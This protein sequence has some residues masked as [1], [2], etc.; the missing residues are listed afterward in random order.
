MKLV[1]TFKFQESQLEEIRAKGVEVKLFGSEQEFADSG[2]YADAD[3]IIANHRTLQR[4]FLEKCEKVKWVQVAHIG[5]ERLPMDYLQERG[6]VVVNARGSLGMPIAED[7]M[8]KMLMLARKS[9]AVMNKQLAHEWGGVRGFINL[10]GKTAGI[11]GTGDVGTETA[12]R[13][14]AFGMRVIGI[15][16]TG[17]QLPEYDRVYKPEQLNEVITQ[18]DF[19]VLSLP[20][21]DQSVNLLGEEQFKLMKPTAFIINISRGALIDEEVLLDYLRGHKIAGAG[22]DVFV[23]E[24]KLGKL[25]PESPF[26]ELDNIIITPHCAGGGDQFNERFT[27]GFMHNLQLFLDGKWEQML[28]VREFGKGY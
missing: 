9:A 26:W 10:N 11:I 20:L 4:D 1:S 12:I 27:G 23:E 3:I 24:F 28:N 13:A 6:V 18:S 19:I 21:T 2:E 15:N 25:P 7:I 5:I 8:C 17:R 16:T 22:L 14:R